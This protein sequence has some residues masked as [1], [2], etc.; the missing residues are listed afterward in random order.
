M[1]IR[2]K[3]DPSAEFYSIEQ[4][5][6]DLGIPMEALQR[7]KNLGIISTSTASECYDF[8]TVQ[9]IDKYWSANADKMRKI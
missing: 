5:S 9:F 3:L 8:K 7:M 6:E 4:I 2:E 1:G